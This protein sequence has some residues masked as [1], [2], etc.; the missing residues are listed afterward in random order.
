MI[1]ES[2]LC[3]VCK[4]KEAHGNCGL[5]GRP[6]SLCEKC[7]KDCASHS[8]KYGYCVSRCNEKK[9][10]KIICC[11]CGYSCGDCEMILCEEHFYNNTPE[12]ERISRKNMSMCYVCYGSMFAT[13]NLDLFEKK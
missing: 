5:C 7:K 8:V 11:N 9:C 1:S 13:K 4:V 10:E 12:E 3:E 6:V 2:K